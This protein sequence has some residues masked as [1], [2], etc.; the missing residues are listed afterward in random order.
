MSEPTLY[1]AKVR[2][3]DTDGRVVVS[4]KRV[5]FDA[6]FLNNGN[7][8][9][10]NIKTLSWTALVSAK[11]LIMIIGTDRGE[12]S[13]RLAEPSQILEGHVL[14]FPRGSLTY[15]CTRPRPV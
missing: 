13:G 8:L 7:E 14:L 11:D 10:S 4:D 1:R 3:V 6:T 12:Q 15:E 9:F 5:L 2:I